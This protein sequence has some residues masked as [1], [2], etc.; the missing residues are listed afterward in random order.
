MALT[1]NRKSELKNLLRNKSRVK[2]NKWGMETIL[3]NDSEKEWLINQ[4]KSSSFFESLLSTYYTYDS[5]SINQFI[6]V[7]NNMQEENVVSDAAQIP[8]DIK[9]YKQ[10][11][12]KSEMID[13]QVFIVSIKE[14]TFTN[15][16]YYGTTGE[17]VT[18][19]V[20]NATNG[21]IKISFWE[22]K[23]TEVIKQGQFYSIKA[24][25][26]N[27]SSDKIDIN[28]ISSVYSFSL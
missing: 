1:E 13:V 24:R 12:R 16:S 5:L 25:I 7:Y 9:I 10:K 14:V 23:Y 21:N 18:K 26:K 2:T 17:R 6:Y 20:Y 15:K 8:L 19:K 4:S 28:Y 22:N 3:L 27:K 11:G